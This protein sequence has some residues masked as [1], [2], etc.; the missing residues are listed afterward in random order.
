MIIS[1]LRTYHK[2]RTTSRI[3]V[4]GE[5][6][7]TCL[8]DAGRPVGVKVQD[9]TCIPEAT[10]KVEI[11]RSNRFQKDMMVLYNV[12][13]DHS[14]EVGGVRFTGI[15]VHSGSTI[16]H[17]AGCPLIR[18]YRELQEM[19]AAALDRMEEVLWQIGREP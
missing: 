9:E 14:V 13:H 18:R 2:D 4:N 17:T 16:A 7:D 5:Y 1:E 6:F 12:D 19:V 10:Y 11:T 3:F 15:R 8:E